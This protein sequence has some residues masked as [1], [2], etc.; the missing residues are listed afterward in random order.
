MI[1]AGLQRFI[2]RYKGEKLSQLKVTGSTG[3]EKDNWVFSSHNLSKVHE[4]IILGMLIEVGILVAMH[5]HVYEFHGVYYLQ[6]V[7]L[8]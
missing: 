5:S 3:R 1:E 2:P 4:R 7:Q 8:G 6:V